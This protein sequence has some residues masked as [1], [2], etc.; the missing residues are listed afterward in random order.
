[1][2]KIPHHVLIRIVL[3]GL[4]VVLVGLLLMND[5]TWVNLSATCRRIWK[6][7]FWYFSKSQRSLFLQQVA[8]FF[9]LKRAAAILQVR[10]NG[11]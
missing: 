1:M 7:D 8:F 3:A 9:C 6:I 4:W 5:R 2:K 11:Q 10:T